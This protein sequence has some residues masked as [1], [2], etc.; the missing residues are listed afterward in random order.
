MGVLSW[1]GKSL[2]QWKIFRRKDKL[3]HL[4]KNTKHLERCTF[5]LSSVLFLAVLELR[6]W[7]TFFI[8]NSN[9]SL[10]Y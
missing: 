7:N 10:T 6:G 5:E 4:L 2:Q 9:A 1:V 8:K 3:L